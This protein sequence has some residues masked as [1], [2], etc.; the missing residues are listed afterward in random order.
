MALITA[1]LVLLL[2]G[3]LALAFVTPLGFHAPVKLL[4]H[5]L[6]SQCRS[7]LYL[8]STSVST[9][10]SREETLKDDLLQQIAATPANSPTSNAQTTSILNT[11]RELE[12]ICPTEDDNNEMFLQK[13]AGNWELLWTTQDDK[14]DEWNMAGPLR[15]WIK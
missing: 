7:L 15:R 13:L 2:V 10:S 8:S 3:N 6:K 5:P 11:V 1:M 9:S 4:Q 12:A 14:S